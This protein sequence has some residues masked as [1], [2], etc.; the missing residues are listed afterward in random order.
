MMPARDTVA[1]EALRRSSTSKRS[2]TLS[3]IGMRS[4]LA[5][6]RS[7]LSSRT[8]FRFSIQTAS[9]GPS[10][11]IHVT[12]RRARSLNLAQMAAKMPLS[13]SPDVRSVSPNISS[14]RIAFGFIRI[15]LCGTDVVDERASC[16]TWMIFDLPLPGG[17][18]SMMPWRTS[19]VSCSCKSFKRQVA[20]STA[21]LCAKLAVTAVS[22]DLSPAPPA[23]A[24]MP[25]KRSSRSVRK[26]ATSCATNL[27]RFM[28]RSVLSSSFDSSSPGWSRFV[29]PAERRTLRMFRR[30]KS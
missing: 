16:K 5:S 20:W 3:A 27:E 6:V 28:D 24:L 14:G 8:V 4:P 1:G 23:G 10:Q 9:T 7:L 13:H 29:W 11:T 17:P 22:N 21:F 2:L 30:P 18:T 26:R 25:G 15:R 19:V 12:S